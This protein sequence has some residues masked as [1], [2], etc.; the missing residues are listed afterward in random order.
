MQVHL[1]HAYKCTK[2]KFETVGFP[3]KMAAVNGV[4]IEMKQGDDDQAS[5]QSITESEQM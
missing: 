3:F 4:V 2:F 5:A 1:Q